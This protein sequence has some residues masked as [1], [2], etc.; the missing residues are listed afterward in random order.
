MLLNFRWFVQDTL[1][2]SSKPC[3]REDVEFLLEQ[4]I[5]SVISLEL[6]HDAMYQ[7]LKEAGIEVLRFPIEDDEDG[8]VEPTD[9]ALLPAISFYERSLDLQRPLLIHCSAGIHRTSF[10]ARKLMYIFHG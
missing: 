4:G 7:W 10:L 1:A 2:G 6:T 5:M 8:M 9:V 3:V